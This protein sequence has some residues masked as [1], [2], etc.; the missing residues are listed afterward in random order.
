MNRMGFSL[1]DGPRKMA[2][3]GAVYTSPGGVR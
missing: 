3:L 2:L 1:V